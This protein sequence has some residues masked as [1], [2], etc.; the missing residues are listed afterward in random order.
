[1]KIDDFFNSFET[2]HNTIPFSKFS[3]QDYLP[4]L[5]EAIKRAKK[6]LDEIIL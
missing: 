2:E 3:D 6:N 4:I 1:M 5:D